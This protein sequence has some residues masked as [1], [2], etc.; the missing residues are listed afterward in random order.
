MAVTAVEPAR[1]SPYIWPRGEPD[2]M[3][4]W[5]APPSPYTRS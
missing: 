5:L 2:G 1:Q 4:Q 3:F